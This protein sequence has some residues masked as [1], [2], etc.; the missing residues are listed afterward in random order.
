VG[1]ILRPT[2]DASVMLHACENGTEPV[3][4]ISTITLTYPPI[5]NMRQPLD[6]TDDEENQALYEELMNSETY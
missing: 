2:A 1:L 6:P 5:L 4:D 3:S